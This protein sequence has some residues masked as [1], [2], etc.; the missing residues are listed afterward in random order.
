MT[1]VESWED[2]DFS[3]WTPNPLNNGTRT[4]ENVF[5][6]QYA[7]KL[8]TD[9]V[10]ITSS[11]GDGLSLYPDPT[12]TYEVAVNEYLPEFYDDYLILLCNYVDANNY[13]YIRYSSIFGSFEIYKIE[14]GEFNLVA[15]ASYDG[16]RGWF[17]IKVSVTQET[18]NIAASLYDGGFTEGA[19]PDVSIEGSTTPLSSTATFGFENTAARGDVTVDD[20]H[21]VSGGQ[22]PAL[23]P[24]AP[25]NLSANNSD[26]ITQT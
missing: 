3:E 23:P 9:E 18:G 6:G 7:L 4:T 8:T 14:N 10:S 25:T 17:G 13:Y 1:I 16:G 22:S 20:I 21:I 24:T 15:D 2:A 26:Q 19:R 5:D 12:Q 11:L